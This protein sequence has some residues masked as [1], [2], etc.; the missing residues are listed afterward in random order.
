MA[1]ATWNGVVIAESKEAEHVEGN[2]YFPLGSVR[3][4][5]LKPSKTHTTCSWKGEAGYYDVVVSGKENKDAAWY[6][7]EPSRAAAKIKN[8]IAFWKGVVA[9]NN[10]F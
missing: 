6:Y 1:K 3:M 9:G 8:H 7:P 2:V 4:K 5:F 10:C